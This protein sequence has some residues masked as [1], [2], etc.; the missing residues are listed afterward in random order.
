MVW[1]AAGRAADEKQLRR[2]AQLVAALHRSLTTV[3]VFGHIATAPAD[4]LSSRLPH[5]VK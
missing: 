2:R 4:D 1:Q 5:Q 3:L